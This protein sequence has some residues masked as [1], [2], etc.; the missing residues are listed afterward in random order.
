[1]SGCS[2]DTHGEVRITSGDREL[3]QPPPLIAHGVA[4]WNSSFNC[5]PKADRAPNDTNL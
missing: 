4:L 1:M 3:Q 2:Y 5:R